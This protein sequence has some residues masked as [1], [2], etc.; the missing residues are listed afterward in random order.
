MTPM[1]PPFSQMK[2]IQRNWLHQ[3][4]GEVLPL[5]WNNCCFQTTVTGQVSRA[6]ILTA[7]PEYTITE[8]FQGWKEAWSTA[9]EF[10]PIHIKNQG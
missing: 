1:Q 10:L 6:K 5:L 9:S 8:S 2:L 3:T 4:S 7:F